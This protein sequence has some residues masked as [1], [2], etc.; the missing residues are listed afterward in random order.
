MAFLKARGLSD[1]LAL[2]IIESAGAESVAA[3][4]ALNTQECAAIAQLAPLTSFTRVYD[5]DA[6]PPASTSLA[7]VRCAH[8]RNYTAP[9]DL[10]PILARMPDLRKLTVSSKHGHGGTLP[11]AVW[12]A[13]LQ[14]LKFRCWDLDISDQQWPQTLTSLTASEAVRFAN[15]A[16]ARTPA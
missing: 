15:A 8:I 3:L 11:P 14:E 2:I 7:G 1:E 4:A 13:G 9:A 12:P 6:P 5:C 16:G 10:T